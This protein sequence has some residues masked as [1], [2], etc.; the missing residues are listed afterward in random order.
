[1]DLIS[2]EPQHLPAHIVLAGLLGSC[3][4]VGPGVMV[5]ATPAF[6]HPCDALRFDR[7]WGGLTVEGDDHC[8]ERTN[9]N[10]RL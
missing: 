5:R 6:P 3:A 1:M 10:E 8:N 4:R 2:G 7:T 9:K